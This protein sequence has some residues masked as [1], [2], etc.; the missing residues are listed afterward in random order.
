MNISEV[1]IGDLVLVNERPVYVTLAVL[2]LWND[3]IKPIPLT[4]E[5][6]EKNG[7]EHIKQKVII[8]SKSQ[9]E[10]EVEYMYCKGLPC[11]F[12]IIHG[13]LMFNSNIDL[14]SIRMAVNY[15]HELQHA[16]KL[17]GINKEIKL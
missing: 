7:F 17:C 4:P 5:I 8:P 2:S 6:L 13:Y 11:S 1:S 16:L 3:N 9:E 12:D 14:C 10:V 15:V